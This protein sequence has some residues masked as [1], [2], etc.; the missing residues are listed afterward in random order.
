MKYPIV[1]LLFI[2][3]FLFA[4]NAIE[5]KSLSSFNPNDELTDLFQ[6]DTIF[7]NVN[8]IGMGEC[9]HGTSEFT[10]MRH[11]IFKYLVK[12]KGFNTIFIEADYNACQRINRY[13]NGSEDNLNEAVSDLIYFAWKTEEMRS[14]MEWARS[15]NL[16]TD[17][18]IQ[19]IG[20]DMQS[21]TDDKIEVERILKLNSSQ[22]ILPKFFET[23]KYPYNDTSAIKTAL[24][25]WSVF[26]NQLL[27]KKNEI[28]NYE[29]L[30]VTVTQFLKHKLNNTLQ[31]NYRD[32]CMAVTILKYFDLN[33]SSKGL[34]IAHNSHISN[35][36][37]T[38]T[39]T[40][41]KK[42]TGQYLKEKLSAKYL[43]IGQTSN[44][45]KFNVFTYNKKKLCFKVCKLK[46]A[47]HSSLEYNCSKLQKDLLICRYSSM[48]NVHKLN[49]TEIGHTYGKTNLGYTIKR[50]KSLNQ[51]NFDYIIYFKNTN[52]T[53]I[54]K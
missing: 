20:C 51:I 1:F 43:N 29:L 33:N 16:S 9:T 19:I 12:Q 41:P 6:L 10:K 53:I 2:Q 30:N 39:S 23:L 25:E 13:I 14:F 3:S 8:L 37:Y 18:K 40:Y 27:S 5:Y 42:F 44:T 21:I 4:Q 24:I 36:I 26:Y 35:T 48:P 45:G 52:E 7:N 11:R 46:T 50:Y 32:S 17:N 34:F 15:Y 22:N 54:L 47:K 28:Q 49:Y 31:Y 38:Y